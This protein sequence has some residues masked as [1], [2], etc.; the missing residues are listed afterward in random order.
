MDSSLQ[1]LD[2]SG[3]VMLV[4]ERRSTSIVS[5]LTVFELFGDGHIGVED[6]TI[7]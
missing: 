3:Q 2:N 4:W 5:R 1:V 6:P 7:R